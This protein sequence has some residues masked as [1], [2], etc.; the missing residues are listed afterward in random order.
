GLPIH[1]A[2]CSRHESGSQSLTAYALCCRLRGIVVARVFDLER[3][4]RVQVLSQ[5]LKV[6]WGLALGKVRPQFR[7]MTEQVSIPT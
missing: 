6:S 3:R 4:M 2:F 5:A 1:L 7:A